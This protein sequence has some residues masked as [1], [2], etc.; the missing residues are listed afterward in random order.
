MRLTG[1]ILLW[2]ITFLSAQGQYNVF[3]E[4]GKVGLKDS[5]GQILIPAQYESLGWGDGAFSVIDK[6]TGYKLQGRWGITN[7]GNRRLTKAEYT[8]LLPGEG[9]ILIAHKKLQGLL[10]STVGCINT[11][12][13]VII[14]FLYDG[15]SISSLRVIAF[16]KSGKQFKFGLLD[17]NNKK[18]LPLVYQSIHPI[19]SL[20]FAVKNFQ[21]KTALFS[22]NGLKIIDFVIDSI[23]SFK[24]KYAIVY[25]N[26]Q[27]GLI[28]RDGQL[29]VEP[30][31]RSIEFQKDGSVR[32][33]QSDEWIFLDA[34]NQ[35]LLKLIADSIVAVEKNVF[36]LQ[37]GGQNQL[38][39]A[40]FNPISPITFSSLGKF[41]NEK[42]VFK[43][44]NKY[45][46]IR[47]NGQVVIQPKF[48]QLI[49]KDKYCIGNQQ[50]QNKDQW[51]LLDSLGNKKHEKLYESIEP[52]GNNL[53]AVKYR[54]FW[55]AI[56]ENGDQLV[57]C[58]YDS[59]IQNMGKN[60]IVIFHGQFGIINL[61]ENWLVIPQSNMIT[62]ISEDKYLEAAGK[63]NFLKSTK[64]AIIYFTDNK[65]EIFEDYLLE[66]LPAGAIWK[67]DLNGRIVSRE[68]HAIE[69]KYI[70]TEGLRA[71]K[72]DGKYGF[73]DSRS[74]LR[75]ANRYEGVQSFSDGL[76]AVK[77]LG[78]WGFINHEERIVV[79]PVYEAVAPF[80]SGVAIVKQK[81]LFGA[82]DKNGKVILLPRYQNIEVL[83]N[84][85][86]IV[87]Q[88]GQQGLA[89]TNGKMLIGPK[90]NFIKDLNNGFVIVMRNQ[91]YGTLTL[92]A[93]STIP[94]I[95]DYM[96]YDEFNNRYIA[97]QKSEWITLD[98]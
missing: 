52:L 20:R 61:Q 30:K 11:S 15:L 16:N 75:I 80:S 47:K 57:A 66:Y 56:N 78:K 90:F 26:L 98:L 37:V 5:Q 1:C 77:L 87:T 50:Y 69:K 49:I 45:G 22:D 70:E 85:R 68:A 19:G 17:F 42:A 82:I 18:I 81:N 24:T 3:K 84:Q 67:I 29:K 46:V 92:Q 94:M 93:L 8:A 71:I 21:N 60:V 89:D 7:I 44:D 12:G 10:K 32:A 83:P 40:K 55:G 41:V 34:H 64:G 28:D 74:R 43:R 31:Y 23:S 25:Q 39:N 4:N 96:R 51:S 35:F 91:K 95:Y 48:D 97:L 9:S 13:K 38:V 59:L 79:Q 76:A 88:D 33:R 14:P 58:V 54:N 72:K 53:F 65:I 86:L 6:V 63:T 62:M 2:L 73:I 36:K 27:Q